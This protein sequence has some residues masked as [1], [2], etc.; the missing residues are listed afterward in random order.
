MTPPRIACLALAFAAALALAGCEEEK[1]PFEQGQ[2]E[3]P[4]YLDNTDPAAQAA[5]SAA[6][7]QDVVR[8]TRD[9]RL[10]PGD[11]VQVLYTT[12]TRPVVR[13]YRIGVGDQIEV[14]FDYQPQLNHAYTVRPDGRIALPM[15]GE[16]VAAE[17]R[18]A[19]L[20]REIA[21]RYSDTFVQPSVTVNVVRFT[22]DAD[23]FMAAVAGPSGPHS[24]NI[25]IA[26]D[27][28][29]T[30]PMLH[31]IDAVGQ[32]TDELNRIVDH[33]YRERLGEVSTTIR[34]N[35]VSNQQIFVFGEVQRPGPIPATRGRTALQL[36][37]AAGGPTEFAA[38]DKVRVLYWDAAGRPLIRQINLNDVMEKLR[39]D[40]DLV[41]PANSVIYVPPT[42]LAK[43]GRFMDQLL[44]RVFLFQGSSLGI[45]FGTVGTFK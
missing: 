9:Y 4:V 28:S 34:L 18:P 2:N 8:G 27:G 41:V 19:D 38:T 10:Q 45:Q 1:R 25:T 21:A 17:K 24:E 7:S 6:L 36:I 29:V 44:R 22:S 15:K 11:V 23:E 13:A 20:G 26:P 33:L 43:A 5:A 16:I 42:A 37:A 12:N 14:N 35:S 32:T 3:A 31:P 30:L 40:E 39:L